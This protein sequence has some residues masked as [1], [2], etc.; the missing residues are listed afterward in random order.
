MIK[1]IFILLLLSISFIACENQ[2]E[3]VADE[4]GTANEVDTSPIH[5][6]QL[7]GVDGVF[8]F[9]YDDRGWRIFELELNRVVSYP[10]DLS[11][12]SQD[13]ILASE[14]FDSMYIQFNKEDETLDRLEV[15]D[16]DNGDHCKIK[17]DFMS[18]IYYPESGV[19]TFTSPEHDGIRYIEEVGDHQILVKDSPKI[20]RWVMNDED[21]F[22]IGEHVVSR[23]SFNRTDVSFDSLP[24]CQVY[25]RSQLETYVNFYVSERME[26][27]HTQRLANGSL[28]HSTALGTIL[29]TYEFLTEENIMNLAF[30]FNQDGSWAEQ[31]YDYEMINDD[32]FYF[33]YVS[34][35]PL[36]NDD[37]NNDED[38]EP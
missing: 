13:E 17:E 18:Y 12:C 25:N 28:C 5:E 30:Q 29:G 24:D 4:S 9:E 1:K 21:E 34:T 14:N 32:K 16:L 23:Y 36:D 19:L 11:D 27:I 3:Q 20:G 7:S 31:S 10:E 35:Q 15:R 33:R 37:D 22:Y 2:L 38:I 26:I 6:E 8:K